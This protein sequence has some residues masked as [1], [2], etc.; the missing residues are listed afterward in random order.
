VSISEQDPVMTAAFEG[1]YIINLDIDQWGYSEDKQ[2]PGFA[3]DG[4]P[5]FFALDGQGRS[6]G[7][8]ISGNDWEENTKAPLLTEFFASAGN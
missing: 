3:F 2:V 1:T 4:I 6:T 7:E 5:I 8:T